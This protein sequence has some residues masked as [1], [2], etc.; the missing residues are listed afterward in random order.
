MPFTTHS[1]LTFTLVCTCLFTTLQTMFELSPKLAVVH[2]EPF[3]VSEIGEPLLVQ[4]K[5]S[6]SHPAF[7][8]STR[9][10]A[11]CCPVPVKV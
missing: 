2:V 5:L 1:L 6:S 8:V 4:V 10:I 9:L 11:A 7:G 3:K